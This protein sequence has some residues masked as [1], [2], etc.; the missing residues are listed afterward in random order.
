M[1]LGTK[2]FE[3]SNPE[4]Q[5][6][7]LVLRV[8]AALS[9]CTKA[10][11]IDYVIA[12]GDSNSKV[13]QTT[14][15]PHRRKLVGDALLKLKGFA[16]IRFT[17]EQIA[18]T[19]EGRRFLSE[20]ELIA[21]R[22][23]DRSVKTA[24]INRELQ[25]QL[26]TRYIA[27]LREYASNLLARYIPRI[28]RS[29]QD[30][31]AGAGHGFLMNGVRARD[32]ALEVWEGKVT[33]IILT[34]FSRVCCKS[35]Q[36]TAN[37]LVNWQTQIGAALWKNGKVSWLS[38]NNKLAGLSRLAI[39]VG[40][41]LVALS[42]AGS[43]ALLSGNRAESKPE[44]STVSLREPPI[45]WFYDGQDHPQQSIFVKRN[46]S[47]ATWI[48][49]ISIRGENKSNQSLTAVQATL[50]SD[51]GE[52]IELTVRATGGQQAQADA[53]NV[54]SGSEF[55]LEYGFHSD[56]SGRQTGMAA[57]E[58]L[59][60]YGGMIFRLGYTVPGAQRTLLEY[61]SPSRLKAQL[62]DASAQR[63]EFD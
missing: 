14:F 9:P 63:R 8:I 54:P 40:V 15:T 39:V 20:L 35:A 41:L 16:F 6:A 50:I 45:V 53:P 32:I 59:S 25:A 30:R 4:D 38:L 31:L 60:K 23:D 44:T 36:A 5:L 11:L 57:E 49:G 18:V 19:D 13:G 47:G 1:R 62:A 29:C 46:F 37:S 17:Q 48:E 33:P 43:V 27:L 61:F 22:R 52:Q 7:W 28:K 42:A 56:A 21:S 34:R 55:S 3:N 51:S 12:A 24:E 26:G 10:S 2:P 58:F